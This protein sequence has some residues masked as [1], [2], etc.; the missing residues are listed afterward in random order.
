MSPTM[1]SPKMPTSAEL[2]AMPTD[3]LVRLCIARVEIG[4]AS[5]DR[6]ERAAERA[7]TTATDTKRI[8]SGLANEVHHLR[9]GMPKT[10]T[11]RLALVIACIVLSVAASAG[12]VAC[13]EARRAGA[14]IHT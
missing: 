4:I 13:A 12:V 2:A 3:E 6:A 5:A 10:W 14:V 9:H 11:G 1:P 8:A 7:A